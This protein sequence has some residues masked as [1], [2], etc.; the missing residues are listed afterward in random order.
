[1]EPFQPFNPFNL[2]EGFLPSASAEALPGADRHA[3][4]AEA[5]ARYAAALAMFVDAHDEILAVH[6]T[7]VFVSISTLLNERLK[8]RKK[9]NEKE[10][11]ILPSNK[12]LEAVQMKL[13]P[14]Q[15]EF[16]R[17]THCATR[18]TPILAAVLHQPRLGSPTTRLAC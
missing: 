9:L 8:E 4:H 3:A 7:Q 10:R 15:H 16:V 13:S 6:P 14:L 17:A 2:P 11:H 1:M 5:A 12:Y 18:T